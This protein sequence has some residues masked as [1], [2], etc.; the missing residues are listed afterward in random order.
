MS[1]YNTY[2]YVLYII[3]Q[4]VIETALKEGQARNITT[5][6][7]RE[8]LSKYITRKMYFPNYVPL[9]DPRRS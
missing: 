7:I 1:N 5:Q 4:A 6:V 3:Y 8:T 2:T 9:V